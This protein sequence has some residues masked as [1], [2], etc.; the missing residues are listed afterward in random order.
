MLEKIYNILFKIESLNP[1]GLKA[2]DGDRKLKGIL[3]DKKI[4]V[5]SCKNHN[6]VWCVQML[7]S[8]NQK[9]DDYR[10]ENHVEV[11]HYANLLYMLFL[12]NKMIQE[13]DK[14][15]DKDGNLR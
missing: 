5:S 3:K 14:L 1:Y 2:Y 7:L 8:E 4:I 11:G 15:S 13:C 9:F 6:Q 10:Y 12:S